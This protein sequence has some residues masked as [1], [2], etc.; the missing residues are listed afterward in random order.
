MDMLKGKIAPI[1][2]ASCKYAV[3]EKGY[4]DRKMLLSMLGISIDKIEH[5]GKIEIPNINITSE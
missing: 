2:N 5:S 3:T 4:Q 1:I